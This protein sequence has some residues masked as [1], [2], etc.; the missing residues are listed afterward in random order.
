MK[1]AGC[2]L[3]LLGEE[4]A[5]DGYTSLLAVDYSPKC[6]QVTTLAECA[7]QQYLGVQLHCTKISVGTAACRLCK[8]WV[9]RK[10]S[11]PGLSR[12]PSWMSLNLILRYAH[13]SSSKYLLAQASLGPQ[14][15]RQMPGV[16]CMRPDDLTYAQTEW[17]DITGWLAS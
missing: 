7:C 4:M 13:H 11:V 12:M 15:H 3:S 2:G 10:R 6:I 1:P 5:A 14:Y 16:V 17:L 9:P 8:T